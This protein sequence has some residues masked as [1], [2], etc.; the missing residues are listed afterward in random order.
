MSDHQLLNPPGMPPAVGFAHA[1]AAAPGR[2]VLVAGQI[3]CDAEG[4]VVGDGFAEQFEAALGHV[5]AALAAAG[6]APE[7]AVAL[8]VYV[9]GMDEYRAARR[10]LASA[11]RAHF[12][13]H[14]PAM[15]V[16][17]VTELVDPAAKVEIAAVAIVPS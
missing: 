13:R 16:V 14:Y 12:G 11:W 7:H 3:G 6:A 10:T 17:G 5:A 4:T 2:P 9:T 1:V 15:A 8:T